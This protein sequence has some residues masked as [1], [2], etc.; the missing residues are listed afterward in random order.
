[1]E[2]DLKLSTDNINWHVLYS[3]TVTVHKISF[4]RAGLP[5]FLLVADQI[6]VCKFITGHN[7]CSNRST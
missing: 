2:I 6:S 1:M 3:C 4:N 5:N 7:R